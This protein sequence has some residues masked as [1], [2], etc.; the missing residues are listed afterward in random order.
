MSKNKNLL[1]LAASEADANLLYA[2][3][4]SAPDPFPLMQIRG[5]TYGFLNDLE[6][7]RAR[8][9]SRI[10]H[11]LS[12]SEYWKLYTRK[13][14][15][16]S[17]A[18][19]LSGFARS[20]KTN[21]FFVPHNFPIYAAEALRR[22]GLRIEVLMELFPARQI[23]TREEIAAIGSA[24]RG[25]EKATTEAIGIIRKSV[26][27]K[28]MLYYHG[29]KLTSESVKKIIAK[30]L[31]DYECLAAHTIVS[32]GEQT[33]D[34][35]NEG[36][37]PLAAHQPIILDIFPRSMKTH[38]Y[39]DF[40]RTVVRGRATP[41]LKKIYA[42]VLDAQR[43]AFRML[44]HGVSGKKVH[45]AIHRQFVQ[46]GFPTGRFHGRMQGFFH[47]TGHGLGLEIHESPSI[48][49]RED[50]LKAGNVMTVEPGLYYEKSGGVRLEDVVVITKTGCVNLTR[51]PKVLEI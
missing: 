47:G 39:A 14:K 5:K 6:I 34:P 22:K 3:G 2:S 29:E 16:P 44:R 26:I 25:V 36:H 43:I 24:L 41:G 37:G 30:T 15:R 23:K 20:K 48:S 28:G 17:L 11:V 1:M 42:A 4:F 32:C 35:H 19:V 33:V 38:Y 21:H 9:Q 51:F 27:K 10:D 50:I 40:T 31:L 12:L 18:D 13:S 7:D 8:K 49:S 45:E 46:R